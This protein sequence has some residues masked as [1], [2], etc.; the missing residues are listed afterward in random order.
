MRA[1]CLLIGL[2]ATG[3]AAAS[4]SP[5]DEREAR[6]RFERGM[7]EYR[8]RN[9]DAAIDQFKSAYQLTREPA[10]LFNLGQASRLAER[11]EEAVFFYRAYLSQSP[12]A[13]NRRDAEEFIDQLTPGSEVPRPHAA[14]ERTALPAPV[15]S[16]T[17]TPA[18]LG[19]VE[20]GLGLA[21]SGTALALLAGGIALGTA[22][23]SQSNQVGASASRGVPWSPQLRAQWAD[24]QRDAAGATA[25]YVVG[26]V[27]GAVGV[28]LT[29][30][31]A[32]RGWRKNFSAAPVSGG[33][34]TQWTF[35]F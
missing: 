20:L 28:I 22:A 24:G 33:V 10:L 9:F 8:V 26:G 13:P 16:V 18:R 14:P 30:L 1:A 11:H 12:D 17:A 5:D 4:P 29:V 31:G 27:S 7:A 3:P 15:P 2:L 6:I 34:R 23:N 25:L 19:R 35:A 32:R 21:F